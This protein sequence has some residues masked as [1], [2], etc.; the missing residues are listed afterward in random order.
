MSSSALAGIA[1][2][3]ALPPQQLS[4]RL[5]AVYALPAAAVGLPASL[6]HFFYLKFATDVLLV[7]PA[8]IGLI[9][10]ISKLWDAISDPMAGY[11]S[12][13]TRSR[14]GR[15]RPWVALSALPLGLAIVALWSPPATLG[16]KALVVW[17]GL[18]VFAFYT[19]H[20]AFNVPHVSWG[21]ELSPVYHERSRVFAAREI[22][23]K[24][25]LFGALGALY[26]LETSS[27]PRG[28]GS[29]VAVGSMAFVAVAC[30]LSTRRVREPAAHQSQC[31]RS[32]YAAVADVWRN[33]D[34]RIL[35][36]VIL[37]E[38]L[39]FA[40]VGVLLPYASEYVL[41]TPG[42]TAWYMLA[43]TLP[44]LVSIPAWLWASRR[45]G[46]KRVWVLS[47]CIKIVAFAILFTVPVELTTAVYACIVA[48]GV[49][50]GCGSIIP[51]S[52]QADVIDVD[53][54][55]TGERK[56]G[57]YFA[58]WNLIGKVALALSLVLA[59][60]AL[61][62]AGFQPNVSQTPQVVG[63]IRFLMAGL[64]CLLLIAAT[65]LLG[66]LSL[67]EASHERLR[68]ALDRRSA[69]ERT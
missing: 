32:P 66:R 11:W 47:L 1:S 10:G 50:H 37:L 13:H 54:Y 7:A 55:A 42:Q 45:L 6:V 69:G 36:G 63:V 38:H 28:A 8:V 3:P 15:R 33:R 24:L 39:G 25:G 60:L 5:L 26:W 20:T 16:D 21:A 4:G 65:A 23:D 52:I 53:E 14:W 43:F 30:W 51:P 9:F 40:A 58:L 64:P 19:A 46:K 59:G 44:I 48:I 35:L 56:A 2:A 18:S 57:T 12:D 49:A 61:D 29:F 68:E 31:P 41:G 62:V 22:G 27:S 34:A 17:I 67:S